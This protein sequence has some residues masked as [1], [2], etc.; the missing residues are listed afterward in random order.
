MNTIRVILSL[1]L[2][3]LVGCASNQKIDISALES[4]ASQGD[5]I[6][7]N[8][9]GSMYQ[10]GDGVT[11]NY[12]KAIEYYQQASGQGLGLATANLG[13]MYDFGLG[14]P[15]NNEKAIELYKVAA[16]AG[17]PSGMLNLGA[18]YGEGQ[19]IERDYV[20][21]YMWFDLARFYTQNSKDMDAKWA[22]RGA[23]ENLSKF[24][25]P[26]QIKQGKVKSSQWSKSFNNHS[27]A[28]H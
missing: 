27:K 14:T 23:L 9:L 8:D 1:C 12:P 2:I 26:E 18:M 17:E 7:Q 22:S 19:G 16:N 21:A 15:E 6:A 13:Y 4:K 25:T 11:K 20:I 5:S 24:M 28:T 10:F 3:L